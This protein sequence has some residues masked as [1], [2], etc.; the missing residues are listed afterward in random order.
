MTHLVTSAPTYNHLNE[1]ER[2]PCQ[3]RVHTLSIYLDGSSTSD[4][5]ITVMTR[6]VESKKQN[7]PIGGSCT[8][9]VHEQPLQVKSKRQN[10]PIRCLCTFEMPKW[11]LSVES[12]KRNPSIR[13]SYTLK[14]PRW[15]LRVESERKYLH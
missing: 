2:E 9:K 3:S 7:S 5:H 4:A 6:S 1:G 11:P 10:L 13:G 15:P 8:L 12:E 14:V